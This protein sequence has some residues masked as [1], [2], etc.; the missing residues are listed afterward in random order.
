AH[1]RDPESIVP[2][3]RTPPDGALSESAGRSV[4]SYMAKVRT[5][6]QYPSIDK[7]TRVASLVIGQYCA[8][9]HMIDGEGGS[10]GPDLTHT[11]AT[12]D[13][14]W[15]KEWIAD[16]SLIDPAAN[17]PPFGDRLSEEELTLLANYLAG[18]K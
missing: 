16:P 11:G 6:A 12:R 17:M 7:E 15:L 13:A 4:V 8:S 3:T 5:G 10:A 1:T 2:G 9:C 14:M 18:R